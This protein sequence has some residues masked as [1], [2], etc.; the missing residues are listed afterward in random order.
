M[1]SITKN[2]N[3]PFIVGDKRFKL[4]LFDSGRLVSNQSELVPFYLNDI[5]EDFNKYGANGPTLSKLLYPSLDPNA[6]ELFM[7]LVTLPSYKI[8]NPNNLNLD[9]LEQVFIT[10]VRNNKE[11]DGSPN[12]LLNK[13]KLQFSQINT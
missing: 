6:F 7:Q 8:R 5:C 10:F 9:D 13:L 12:C 4:P 11:R 1:G 2:K 3:I